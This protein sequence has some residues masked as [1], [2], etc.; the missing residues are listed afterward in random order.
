MV[1]STLTSLGKSPKAR[2]HIPSLADQ[3]SFPFNRKNICFKR[4]INKKKNLWKEIRKFPSLFFHFF[5]TSAFSVPFIVL[6]NKIKPYF[7]FFYKFSTFL[8]NHLFLSIVSS[9]HLSLLLSFN[10]GSCFFGIFCLLPPNTSFHLYF[11]SW[12][13]FFML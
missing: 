10:S 1:R 4:S 8:K 12:S 13:S 3:T 6:K 9:S 7:A 11:F 2:S 5:R